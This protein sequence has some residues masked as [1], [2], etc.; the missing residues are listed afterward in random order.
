MKTV[1]KVEKIEPTGHFQE[2]KISEIRIWM[3][4][5]RDTYITYL[6]SSLAKDIKPSAKLL[7]MAI[8]FWLVMG[9]FKTYI[10]FCEY[11]KQQNEKRI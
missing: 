1:I 5:G 3:I 8:A 6:E 7:L 4:P 11:S 10:A 2:I 9:E